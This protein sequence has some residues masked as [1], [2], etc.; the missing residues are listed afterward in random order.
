[1]PSQVTT[2]MRPGAGAKGDKGETGLA[3]PQGEPG[4]QGRPGTPGAQGERGDIGPQGPPGDVGPR[5]EPG[6]PGERGLQ[7]VKGDRGDVG[8]Q[9]ER[10]LTG[11][12]GPA[13]TVPQHRAGALD[14]TVVSFTRNVVFSTPMPSANYQVFY[15][16]QG[17]GVSAA[18]TI[19]NKTATGFTM[20]LSVGVAARIGWLAIEDR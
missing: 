9:G 12:Q 19:S 16:S 4:I 6:V 3:G 11:L 15:A 8:A 18:I 10:G 14:M 13:G 17:A 2:R 1:M 7:G 5:G 20:G